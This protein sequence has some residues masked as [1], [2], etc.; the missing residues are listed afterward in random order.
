MTTIT[1]ERLLEII[2]DGFLKHG[3]SK[4]LAR[5]ALSSLEAEPDYI[6]Y[7][8]GYCGWEIIEDWR[9]SDVC[10]KCNHKPMDKT[11]LYAVPPS[12][13]ADA[14]PVAVNDDMAYA[15]HHA[16]SDSSPGADELEEIK[17]GLRAAFANITAQ[18]APV[19]PEEITDDLM[20]KC[21]K[22]DAWSNGF[23]GGWNACRAAVLSGKCEPGKQVCELT[24]L[25]RK[26]AS[27]LK[28]A[29]PD[30]EL[31]D[32]AIRYLERNRLISMEDVLR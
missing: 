16:L 8:C 27:R 32:R 19:V 31:P 10:P 6:R 11:E 7:E 23:R 29:K 25:V 28:N 30:C 12:Q 14:K 1:R 13:V 20:E 18:P 26:L 17:T 4:E 24:M 21:P 2:A 15:F 22:S 5:I 3:E 9:E